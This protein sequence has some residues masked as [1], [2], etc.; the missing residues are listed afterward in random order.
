[1]KESLMQK[2]VSSFLY[3]A[4]YITTVLAS[5]VFYCVAAFMDPGY[6]PIPNKVHICNLLIYTF[7]CFVFCGLVVA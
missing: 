6:V 7:C 2:S 4:A 1:M 3:V 5:L